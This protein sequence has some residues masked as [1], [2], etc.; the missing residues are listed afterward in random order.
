VQEGRGGSGFSSACIDIG[1]P[2]WRLEGGALARFEIGAGPGG[3]GPSG[4]G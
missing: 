4:E 1:G 2:C 3:G